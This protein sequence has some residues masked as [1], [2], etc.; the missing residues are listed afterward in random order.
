MSF[1]ISGSVSTLHKSSSVTSKNID[2]KELGS[3]WRFSFYLH[4][5]FDDIQDEVNLCDGKI[6][7]MQTSSV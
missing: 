5:S 3:T 4:L 1:H 7:K 6:D 2:M